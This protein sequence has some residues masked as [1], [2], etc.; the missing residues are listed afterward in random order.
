MISFYVDELSLISHFAAL[1][2]SEAPLKAMMCVLEDILLTERC[3]LWL[4]ANFY[5]VPV[6]AVT[7]G[8]HIFSNYDPENRDTITRLRQI[9]DRA[10]PTDLAPLPP[11]VGYQSL[12]YEGRGGIVS[13][14]DL[15]RTSWWCPQTMYVLSDTA[16]L[17]KALRRLLTYYD[18]KE[19]DVINFCETIFPNIYFHVFPTMKKLG[20]SYN[21]NAETVMRHLSWLND[22][23]ISAFATLESHQVV[24]H[25]KSVKVDL[26][27]E[28]TQTRADKGAMRERTV[29]ISGEDICCEWHTK[30]QKTGGRIHFHPFTSGRSASLIATAGNKI[31]VGVVAYHLK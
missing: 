25:A 6:G 14:F 12:Q 13:S 22:Q 10:T 15:E 29:S 24:D 16:Q 8:E 1:S 11:N 21:E 18:A 19:V 23:A 4:P 31:I 2:T 26:S 5:E 27:S 17:P 7:V 20:L 9:I 30:V 28:S 3:T